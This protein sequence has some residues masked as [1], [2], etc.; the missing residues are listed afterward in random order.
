MNA[1]N[2]EARKTSGRGLGFQRTR[3]VQRLLQHIKLYGRKPAYCATEFIEDSLVLDSQNGTVNIGVEE[4]KNYSSG[5]SLNS[6]PIKNT[7]V[8]FADQ[9]IASFSDSKTIDYSIFCLAKTADENID[10]SLITSCI[11]DY[12]LKTDKK[13]NFSILKKL[14]N[15]EELTSEE[16]TIAKEIFLNEYR[17]QY[18]KYVDKEKTTISDIRGYYKTLKNWSDDDFYHFIKNISFIFSD[19]DDESFEDEVISNIKECQFYNHRHHGLESIILGALENTF[20]KRQNDCRDFARFVGRADVENLFLKIAS[21]HEQY[22][23][24]DPSWESFE[25]I[26]TDDQRNL[27]DKYNDVCNDVSTRKISILSLSATK[28]RKNEPIFGREY[29]SLRCQLYCW[30]SDYLDRHCKS[31]T[32]SIDL[33]DSHLD[34]MT[35]LC[36][37]K[38]KE[39]KAT[40]RIRIND[41]ENLKGIILTLFDDCYLA[42]DEK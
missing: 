5:L 35:E 18:T 4:N 12:P 6:D 20:D 19:I 30:C 3:A 31:K 10:N 27:P 32:Y 29:V 42:Y 24:I 15:K 13:T 14:A 8:A 33:L 7:L 39:L 36:Y 9:Y 41:K 23:P 2:R 40:Y 16:I 11:P 37:T 26:N 1:I 22:K 28:S 34:E 17:S 25:S 38:V 21:N